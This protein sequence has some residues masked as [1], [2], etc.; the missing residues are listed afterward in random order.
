MGS[1][2]RRALFFMSV[3][4][5]SGV[6]LTPATSH[7]DLVIGSA[8][9]ETITDLVLA[10]W[11]TESFAIATT[12]SY[13]ECPATNGWVIFTLSNQSSQQAYDRAYALALSAMSSNQPVIVDMVSGTDCSTAYMLAV[14]ALT[15]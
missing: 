8:S 2:K 12:N 9:V 1:L 10:P 15:Q 11:G 5:V 13:A 14:G 6:L 4:L 3:V 7:A